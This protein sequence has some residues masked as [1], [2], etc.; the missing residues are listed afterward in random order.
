MPGSSVGRHYPDIGLF[1]DIARIAERGLFDMIFFGDG[2]GIPNTWEGGI[3]AVRRG[4]AAA[5]YE[6][7]DH[8]DV[9]GRETCR[10]RADLRDHPA[11]IDYLE[12]M[13]EPPGSRSEFMLGHSQC[14]HTT[15][16]RWPPLQRCFARA[17]PGVAWSA[18]Q[19][20]DQ[21]RV[22]GEPCD[23]V[24][25]GIADGVGASGQML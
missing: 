18:R 23:P 24:L 11:Q 10:L 19:L 20:Q 21:R 4:L 17:A 1:E 3:G 22:I 9:T 14:G 25:V 16:W 6:P 12:D 13:F 15:S 8:G 7:V 2:S 5:R